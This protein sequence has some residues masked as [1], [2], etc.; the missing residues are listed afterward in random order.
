MVIAAR[1]GLFAVLGL[2]GAAGLLDLPLTRPMTSRGR[3]DTGEF[4][5]ELNAQEALMDQR[6]RA[7][8]LLDRF[9]GAEITR[10]FWGGFSGYLDVLGI[11][12]PEDMEATVTLEDQSVQLLLGAQGGSETY[13][14]RVE[15][16]DGV[17]RGVVC[18]GEG[19]PGAFPLRSSRLTCPQGWAPLPNMRPA[20][21]P[22]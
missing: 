7:A 20:S 8:V 18:R 10:Y 4:L 12:K 2:I 5:V 11:E 21:T 9:V 16:I 1:V 19:T 17:P 22:G 3:V 15:A 13:V 6:Q 14:A